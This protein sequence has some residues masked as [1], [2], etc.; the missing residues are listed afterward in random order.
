MARDE[1]DRAGRRDTEARDP[2]AP[3]RKDGEVAKILKGK[4]LSAVGQ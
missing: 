2:H 3:P 1:L 4:A